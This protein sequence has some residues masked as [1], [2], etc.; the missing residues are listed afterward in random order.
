VPFALTELNLTANGLSSTSLELP[1][2]QFVV[3]VVATTWSTAKVSLRFSLTDVTGTFVQSTFIPDPN[4]LPAISVYEASIENPLPIVVYGPC[5]LRGFVR[6]IGSASG[7]KIQ[8]A[9]T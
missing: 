4:K 8:Y 1:Q 3:A 7:L 9:R 5:Y 6:D 2:G